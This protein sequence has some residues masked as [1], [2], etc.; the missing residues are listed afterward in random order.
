M[1][2]GLDIFQDWFAPYVD[3]YVPELVVR[4]AQAYG[5]ELPA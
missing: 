2:R 1:V 3:Q 5:I 4:I